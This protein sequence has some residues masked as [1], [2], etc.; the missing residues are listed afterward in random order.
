MDETPKKVSN[1]AESCVLCRKTFAV[2]NEKVNVFGKSALDIP[3]LVKHATNVDLSV[4]VD[5]QK[6]AICRTKCYNRLVRLKNAQHKLSEIEEEIR[7]DFDGN[8]PF[9]VKRL[10]KD[11]SSTPEA[12]RGLNFGEPCS[13][14]SSSGVSTTP[15]VT[16]LANPGIFLSP[17]PS[18]FL[19]PVFAPPNLVHRAFVGISASGTMFTSTP[20][21]EEESHESKVPKLQERETKV[22]LRVEYPSKP[23][24]KE[25]KDDYAVIG[26]AIAYGS[27]QRIAR[28][29]LKSETLKKFIVEKVLQL[30]TLQVNGLCSRRQPSM[31]RATT[32]EKLTEF[33]FKGLCCEWK[34]RAPIFYAFLMTCANSRKQNNPEWLPSVA[35][36]GSIL[37]KQRNSHMNGCAATLGILLKS[38]SLESTLNRLAKMKVT[39]SSDKVREK[40]DVLGEMHDQAVVDVQKN[41][42]E[43]HQTVAEKE[44]EVATLIERCGNTTGHICTE[45]CNQQM[46]S[47]KTELKQAKL[48]LDSG[49]AIVFDNID[50]K[51]ERRHMSKDNQNFDFHWVN[52]KVVMNR[53][54]L[55]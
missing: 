30:M 31:L 6:L 50:G 24:H 26:K 29:V 45:M 14:V 22:Y 23:I 33:D 4:Y 55:N 40:L 11:C 38:N 42:S 10:A 25:L 34:E 54:E 15:S 36:S 12:K 32:K 19:T 16:T 43:G 17:I 2:R 39:C 37:L 13:T 51:L 48:N 21:R 47:V 9:R 41:M 35:V 46:D 5:H 1:D 27:P 52:H 20:R 18:T 3:A 28:A 53:I 8:V 7:R 44:A 49:F